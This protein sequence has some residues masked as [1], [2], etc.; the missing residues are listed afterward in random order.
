MAVFN[1]YNPYQNSNVYSQQPMN[2][3]QALMQPIYVHGRAGAEAFQ[4]SPGVVR[5]ILWDDETDRFY[6]KALDEMGRPRIVADKDFTDHVEPIA[7]QASEASSIDFSVYPTKRDLEEFLS[8]FDVSNYL[9]KADFD[10]ALGQ[11]SLGVG[12][13]IVRNE[14]NA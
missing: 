10:K 2:T 1:N 8:K 5:Q 3:V 7:P 4:L 9:T 6:V 11:L 14:S 12:G 13:R